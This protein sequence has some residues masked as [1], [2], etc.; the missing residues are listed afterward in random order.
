MRACYNPDGIVAGRT[1]FNAY[2]ARDGFWGVFG[3]L[4]LRDFDQAKKHLEFF[5]SL[6]KP[7]G[8]LPNKVEFIGH[9]LGSYYERRTEPK[10][11]FR[12]SQSLFQPVDP[13]ALFIIAIW[14]YYRHTLDTQFLRKFSQPAQRAFTWLK[15]FDRDGDL[16][17][18]TGYASDW[19]DSILK[20]GKVLNTNV[21]YA[22]A[23]KNLA[24]IYEVLGKERTMREYEQVA[25]EL[26]ERIRKVFWNGEYLSDWVSGNRRGRFSADGNVLAMLF[27]ITSPDQ[28][29]TVFHFIMRHRL[30]MGH[31]LRTVWPPYGVYE[32]VPTY[33]VIGLADYH[34]DLIWPW[35]GSLNALN[36]FRLGKNDQALDDLALI[37]D[38]YVARNGVAEVY[39]RTGIPV[40]RLFYQSEQPFAWNAACFVYAAKSMGLVGTHEV[41]TK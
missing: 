38:W 16:L 11:F 4:E 6:Q 5:R 30:D 39:N 15:S 2:W 1:H 41:L 29:E 18:E 20:R 24:A 9:T 25:R 10:S 26:Y 19:M 34:S 33:T 32:V 37:A 27:K 13:A 36:K 22:K 35:I 17:L 14:Q 21:I 3:A 40:N 7:N 31:P 8:Q 28:A 12:I 23:S